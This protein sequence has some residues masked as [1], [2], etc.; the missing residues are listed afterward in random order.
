MDPNC[1]FGLV[2]GNSRWHW[3]IFENHTLLKN[4]HTPPLQKQQISQLIEQKLSAS[5]WQQIDPQLQFPALAVAAPASANPCPEI[6][7]AS[8]VDAQTTLLQATPIVHTVKPEQ[9]PLAGAY[10]TLGL[11]RILNLWGASQ[12]YGWP[13]LVVDAG[14]A[15]TLTAGDDNRVLGGM[16][17]P[18]LTLQACALSEKIVA[19]PAMTFYG[20]DPFPPRW[21]LSTV[22][23]IQ[24]GILYT[25]IA[26][27][28]DHIRDWWHQYPKSTIVFTGGDGELLYRL[29]KKRTPVSDTEVRLDLNLMF[30]GLRAYRRLE[31]SVL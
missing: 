13:V 7:M 11:D 18:G 31:I 5:A 2:V 23:A 20:L 21:A 28:E 30:W 14:T 3:A 8:V 15:L 16:I 26:G 25:T 10:S 17:L 27:I 24:S 1:W 9:L 19:L 4:W 12:R 6:W 22:E 29:H